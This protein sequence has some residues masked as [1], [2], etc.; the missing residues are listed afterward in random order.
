MI[1]STE[2]TRF[3]GFERMRV[4]LA[5]HAY[6]VGPNSAGKSTVLEA[7]GLANE[8]LRIWAR[9]PMRFTVWDGGERRSA[10]YL[11][12]PPDEADDPVRFEFGREEARVTV[13]WSGG[14]SVIMVW[15]GDGDDRE[16][17]FF[18]VEHAGPLR[19]AA[20]IQ[21]SFGKTTVVPVITPLDRFEDLKNEKY[22]LSK[23]GTRLTSRHFRNHAYLMQRDGEWERFKHFCRPWLPDLDLMDV[24]LDAGA[25]R[26]G[27]FYSERGSRVPK[28]LAWAGDGIQIWV[29]LLWHLSRA[30][31]STT[32]LLDEPEVYLHPDLQ[33]RLVRLL[34]TLSAQIILASH[35]SDVI[36]EAPPEGVVW[37][38]RRVGRAQRPRTAKA[39]AALSASLGTTYNLA[40]ARTSRAR[41]VVAADCNDVR[42]L[43]LLAAQVGA[44][45]LANEHA[46]SL[47]HLEDT[48]RWLATDEVGQ[49]LRDV[50]PS[51][52]PAVVL[53][54]SRWLPER[55]KETVA[56]EPLGS[57]NR[58]HVLA[59]NGS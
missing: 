34:D 3:R 37:L 43:R 16:E 10:A 24:K 45:N 12:D 11:P 20:A 33:R 31:G 57:R 51:A 53:L 54:Q 6:L 18:Y 27:V 36:A 59:G 40:L 8:C 4:G 15:P 48:A 2:F 46:V 19:N 22:V 28:E 13:R 14:S 23:A 55:M 42:I 30:S 58:C 32:I 9:K 26:L 50:L 7:V 25:D 44:S 5:P 47:L 39:L 49:A 29:Q 17:P 21:A 35:S 41:L 52:L 38:D 1:E 56:K